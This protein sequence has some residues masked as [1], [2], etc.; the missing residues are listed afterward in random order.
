MRLQPRRQR[1]QVQCPNC[2]IKAVIWI[3]YT[4]KPYSA[5]DVKRI[6]CGACKCGREFKILRTLEPPKF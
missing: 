5:G 6:Y 2:K 3:Q 4:I 1:C